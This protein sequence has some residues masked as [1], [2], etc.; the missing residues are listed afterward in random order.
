V[1]A[2]VQLS[3][4]HLNDAGDVIGLTFRGNQISKVL[5]HDGVLTDIEEA[6]AG[7]LTEVV[8]INNHGLIAGWGAGPSFLRALLWDGQVTRAVGDPATSNIAYGL[9]DAGDVAGSSNRSGAV[10]T[11]GRTIE[12]APPRGYAIAMASAINDGGDVAGNVSVSST[13][14]VSQ[15]VVW[16]GATGAAAAA[17]D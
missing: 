12:L 16:P 14:Y 11:N 6:T 3:P 10:W 7:A 8:G 9:N 4:L 2:D 15:A 17:K 5:W 1:P 13:P